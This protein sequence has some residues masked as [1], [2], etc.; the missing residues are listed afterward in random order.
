MEKE[1]VKSKLSIITG[2][3]FGNALKGTP[4]TVFLINNVKFLVLEKKQGKNRVIKC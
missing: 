4:G 1:S 2:K 3:S